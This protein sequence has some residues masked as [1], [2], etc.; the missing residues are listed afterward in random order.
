MVCLDWVPMLAFRRYLNLP[1]IT[2]L[3]GFFGLH[4]ALRFLSTSTLSLAAPPDTLTA[5]GS[6]FEHSR[7]EAGS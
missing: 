6:P 3:P 1:K 4:S 2:S 7:L 5:L